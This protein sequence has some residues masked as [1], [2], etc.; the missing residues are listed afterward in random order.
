MTKDARIAAP[1]PPCSTRAR[2][3]Q[4][5]LAGTAL[6]THRFLL[7]E[8]PGPWGPQAHPTGDLPDAVV[9]HVHLAANELAARV[10]L[11]RRPGRQPSSVGRTWG[12]A[13]LERGDIRWGYSDSVD[14]LAVADFHSGGTA[15]TEATYLVC[16]H[17]RHDV[18]CATEGRP[19]AAALAATVPESVW[20]CSH[21]GGDRFAANV[22]VL[23]TGIVYGWVK[24]A[25][26]DRLLHAQQ[27]GLLLPDLLRGRCGLSPASQVAESL[28]RADWDDQRIGAL[29]VD[30]AEHQGRDT[31]RVTGGLADGGRGFVIDLR[32]Q[33]APLDSGLTC[34]AVATSSM[35]TWDLVHLDSTP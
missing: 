9:K 32:E 3:R 27:S 7:V 11:I 17:G 31:W 13:D 21:V 10:L 24:P 5:S 8:E 1:A 19:V 33:H 22:L 6:P 26:V 28:I 14:E 15:S 34:A 23:P 29:V 20:E 4:D 30:A 12:F 35:R 25:D 18:C 2:A 16:T